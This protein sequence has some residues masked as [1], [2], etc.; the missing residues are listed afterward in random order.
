[1]GSVRT[2]CVIALLAI[3]ATSWPSALR[4]AEGPAGR[5]AVRYENGLV[6]LHFESLPAPAAAERLGA[7]TGIQL[8]LPPASEGKLL[9]LSIQRRP[10]VAALRQFLSAAGVRSF[11]LIYDDKGRPSEVLVLE[12]SGPLGSSSP[13]GSPATLATDP[14]TSAARPVV[15][16]G[17]PFPKY[18]PASGMS[19]EEYAQ[20]R[21]EVKQT[22]REIKEVEKLARDPARALR[23]EEQRARAWRRSD[24]SPSL[25]SPPT[26]SESRPQ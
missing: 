3:T 9:T 4:A 21:D 7:V 6:S 19:R 25:T 26:T 1:M 2:C 12:G 22:N 15:P 17:T 11:A 24:R 14:R 16:P 23:R 20:W 10:L 13:S 5:P 18:D 8:T